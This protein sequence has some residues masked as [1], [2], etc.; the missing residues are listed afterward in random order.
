MR[1]IREQAIIGVIIL[2]ITNIIIT[3]CSSTTHYDPFKLETCTP[4][5]T[6]PEGFA[7][8]TDNKCHACGGEHNLCC[9]GN[10]CAQGLVCNQGT[11]YTCGERGSYCCDS[12]LCEEGLSCLEGVCRGCGLEFE[13]CC[14]G[15]KCEE[16]TYCSDKNTCKSCFTFSEDDTKELS[17][18]CGS[19]G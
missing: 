18:A 12:D 8:D 14:P 11:C 15:N 17:S 16:G 19:R 13:P 9:P 5:R 7:C 4:D 3:G 2:L 6:C 10:T 1:M